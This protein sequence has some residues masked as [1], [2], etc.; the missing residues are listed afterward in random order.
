MKLLVAMGIVF[1]GMALGVLIFGKVI[2]IYAR[3]GV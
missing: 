3:S 1:V 2:E